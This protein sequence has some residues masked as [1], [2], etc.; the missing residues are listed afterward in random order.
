MKVLLAIPVFNEEAQVASSIGTLQLFLKATCPFELRIVIAENG[1]TD[2]T[3]NIANSLAQRHS[4]VSVV[5][6]ETKG[7]GRA[8]KKVWSE[9]DADILSYMD[10]DLSTDLGSFPSLVC[11]LTSGHFDLAVGSRLLPGS[12][13]VRT[14]KRDM[15]SR[16]YN[17]LIK[18]LFRTK[19]S[20]AQC[21]F[22][23]ITRQAASCLLPL[24]DDEGW[25]FDTE[26]LLVAEK[27]GYR[28]FEQP[29]KWVDDP[30]SRVRVLSTI[31]HDINGLARVRRNMRRGAYETVNA[32]GHGGTGVTPR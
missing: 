22:K 4:G 26:L 30:D 20:D 15:I 16:G 27:C 25:F 24:I 7:R 13:T 28:I 31:W 6:L 18:C 11:A 23:A 32:G 3:L 5:H 9:S 10:V 19:F 29:V 17:T 12:T 2:D 1:S 21:G 8:L 14:W